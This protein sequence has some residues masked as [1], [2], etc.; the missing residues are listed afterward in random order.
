MYYES[1][2]LRFD[3]APVPF[4]C[5]PALTGPLPYKTTSQI[6]KANTFQ[7]R[8]EQL[9]FVQSEHP[10]LA[11]RHLEQFLIENTLLSIQIRF[12]RMHRVLHIGPTLHR[13]SH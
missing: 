12:R 6:T 2:T 1:R 5:R 9:Y 13:L 8:V 11:L 7:T 10:N 4:Q 3:K